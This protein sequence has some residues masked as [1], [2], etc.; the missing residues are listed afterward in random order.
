MMSGPETPDETM[1]ARNSSDICIYVDRVTKIK[2][3]PVLSLG[4]SIANKLIGPF[5]L[6]NLS[7]Y[8]SP[9]VQILFNKLVA[10]IR[11]SWLFE[12]LVK[13]TIGRKKCF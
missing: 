8:K 3:L 7:T 9:Q 1:V 2:K 6:S 5:N 11:I 10:R 12:D 13:S 4:K